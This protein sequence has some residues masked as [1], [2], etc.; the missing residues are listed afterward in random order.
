MIRVF[1]RVVPL[2]GLLAVAVSPASL[3]SAHD[4]EPIFVKAGHLIDGRGGAPI[5]PA[6]VRI[7]GGRFVAV[8]ASLP[9]P[10]GARVIDLGSATLL[11]G[12]I[13][14]HTHLTDKPGIHWEDVLVKSTPAE[15]ALWGARNAR[16][17]LEAGFTT[18][19]D[20]GPTWPYTDVALRNAIDEGAV[21]GPR[22]LV[23]GA[24]VSS[25]GGGGDARQFSIYVDVP[26]VRNLADSPAE[27]IKAVRTNFKNGADFIKILA[28][29]AVLSKGI[30]PGAQQY[31]DD[32]IRA[33][34]NEANKWG[35]HVAAHAHGTSG[36]KAAIRAGV[37]TIDHGTML[38]A[39][40]VELLK[41]SPGTYL[42][43]TLLT[44]EYIQ[45]SP[46][47]P[48]SEKARDRTI[49]ESEIR[50]FTLALAA[51]IPI[52][53]GTD[54]AV[55][56]HGANAGELRIRV[57]LGETPMSAIVSATRL[58]AEIMGWHDRVGA[59][60]AS[61]FADLIAVKG[62]PLKDI[63]ELE[64]VGF[65]MKAGAVVKDE[66]SARSDSAVPNS[67]SQLGSDASQFVGAWRLVRQEGRHVQSGEL[68]AEA[69]SEAWPG[70]L[71]YSPDGWMSVTIDRR[72]TG[73]TYWGYFGRF[74]VS[75]DRIVHDI[76]GGIPSARG[77]SP[78]LYRFEDQGRQLVISTLPSAQ[79][80][81]VHY[82]FRRAQ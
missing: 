46:S 60:E 66:L 56:P 36:I 19:R 14:L 78:A 1:S 8:G 72:P 49:R 65:V 44:S 54:A 30:E 34:V 80:S 31:S 24:Y 10:A 2:L 32:E 73:G 17:T 62:D 53:L 70:L 57:Q 11:P 6:M 12:L 76:V 50:S 38:D 51:G 40:A 37:R 74:S 63:T 67:R 9:V 23:S 18:C 21:P 25:T 26:M 61:R 41:K 20:M 82:S 48:E 59:I 4:A 33:A 13:D 52:G 81:V 16:V 35:R 79:G 43:P 42:V 3:L 27:V 69:T 77:P 45:N 39:E 71:I 58:N 29:G 5:S 47:T 15:A 28:T 68:I 22:L 75:G 64:R 55:I 7:K